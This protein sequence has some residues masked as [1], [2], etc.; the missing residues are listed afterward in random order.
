MITSSNLALLLVLTVVTT[1]V[2]T[3][4]LV[5]PKWFG[6]EDNYNPEKVKKND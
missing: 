5:R 2:I 6:L 3:A 1:A 4:L